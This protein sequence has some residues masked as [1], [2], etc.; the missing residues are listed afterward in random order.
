M[1][2]V[3]ET[4]EEVLERI[5]ELILKCGSLDIKTFVNYFEFAETIGIDVYSIV[6]NIIENSTEYPGFNTWLYEIC[7]SI[8]EK[9]CD[10]VVENC[11]N[12]KVKKLVDEIRDNNSPYVNYMDSWL[13]NIFD[14]MDFKERDINKIIENAINICKDNL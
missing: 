9:L 8:T 2:E 3:V 13:N 4:K 10:L 7:Y 12:K 5:L 1:E 6:D 11:S 14:E